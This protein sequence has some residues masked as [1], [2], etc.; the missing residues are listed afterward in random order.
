MSIKVFVFDDDEL[1]RTTLSYFLK[2]E[3]FLV[4]EFAQPD[5]C[6]LYYD[7]N[8]LCPVKNACANIIITDINM[9]GE[10]GL[11]FVENQVRKGCKV[12][13]VAVM[14]GDWEDPFLKRAQ[15]L[16]CQIFYKPFSIIE[17]KEWLDKIRR[18]FQEDITSIPQTVYGK[19][20]KK[21]SKESRTLDS[22]SKA[23]KTIPK[24][25]QS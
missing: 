15:Q 17:M 23:V 25:S 2:Q 3:G 12:E 5:H 18:D 10:N 16:G 14:S 13:H 11:Q 19:V 6:S 9:P 4:S 7:E 20:K 21:A 8:C 22:R 24:P 1:I